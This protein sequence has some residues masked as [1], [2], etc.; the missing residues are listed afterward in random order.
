[1]RGLCSRERFFDCVL[2]S[3]AVPF[4][5]SGGRARG[6][7]SRDACQ[8]A[9][10]RGACFALTSHPHAAPPSRQSSTTCSA[11]GPG[12]SGRSNITHP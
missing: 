1:M 2:L 9:A 12:G 4:A 10:T 7:C 3:R 8:D 6:V 5:S 11:V